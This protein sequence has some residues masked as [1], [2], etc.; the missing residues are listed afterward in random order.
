MHELAIAESLV[1][2]IRERVAPARVTRV[3]LE[4]GA[5]CCVEPE[6]VRFSFEVCARGTCAEGAALE[7]VEARGLARCRACRR[8][9]EVE[10]PVASCPCGGLDLEIVQGDRLLL[11]AVE[12]A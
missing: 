1:E 12:L 4:V 8:S 9:V 3:V 5:L 10:G 2:T 11:K 7:C 6:A